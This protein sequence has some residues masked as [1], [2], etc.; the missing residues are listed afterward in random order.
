MARV[1]TFANQKGGVGKTTTAVNIGEYLTTKGRSV[2]VVDVDPQSN[3]T[4]SL[5][6]NKQP[7]AT[8]GEGRWSIYHALIEGV[9]VTKMI[10]TTRRPR[11]HVIPSSPALAG[12]EVELVSLLARE[13]RLRQALAPVMQHYHYILI[14]T[15][16]SLGLLTINALVATE[17]G[18]IIPVQCEYLALEGLSQLMHTIELVRDNLNARLA[19]SGVVLTMYD[20]RTRLS[21]EVANEVRQYFPRQV[22]KTVIPRNIRLSEA[23]S[24]GETIFTYAPES[25]GALAYAALTEELLARERMAEARRKSSEYGAG[26]LP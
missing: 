6:I 23:P 1:Y 3:A 11:L 19:V 12:A 24:F 26:G 17:T 9:P 18:V 4:S 10:A 14:D 2:L 16:P 13:G 8:G 22:F 21:Q 5:G 25:A 20:V 7:N 15:P